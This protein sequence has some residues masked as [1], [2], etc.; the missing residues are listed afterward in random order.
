MMRNEGRDFTPCPRCVWNQTR[1][2][3]FSSIR[4][5]AS[6][7]NYMSKRKRYIL[8]EEQIPRQW[9][10][11]QADM[12][13]KPMPPLHP[14]TR[15]PLRPE[16]L[17]PVFA[18]ELCHQELNQ[19][20]AWI[21]IPDDVREKYKYYR[22]TPLVRA[23]GLE[24]AL[25]TPA[26]IYFKNESVSPI[27]SHKINS[28]L[29]QAYYCKQEGVTNVT[30][31]T[32]AGQWGAALSYAAKVY[33]LEAAVYQVKISYEQKP[34]RRSVMQVFG[35]QVT[36][37]PSM[38]TRAGKDILTVRPNYQGSL[39]TA[40]S[41]AIELARMTPNCKYTLGS[42]LSHVTLHQT[43]IGLEAEKQME[44]AG[45]Y[46]D[47]VIA[48]FGGGSNFGGLAF[49][50]MR[51]NIKDGK[52]TR[53]IAAEPESCPKLTRGKFRYDFGDEAGYTPLLPMFTLGHNF[54]P[55][56][57]HAGGLRYHG[58]GVIVSQLLMDGLMEAVDIPQL[59]SF[60]AGVL[61][62]RTEGI[63][64]A[65]ESCH[66]IAATV[67]EALKC[68]ETGEKKVILFNLSGHGLIDMASYDQYNS[69]N[70]ANYSI[71]DQE[72]ERNLEAL[73]K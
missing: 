45:E 50:F 3:S 1:H 30:T 42:V 54:S 40:I 46:P 62:A 73:D 51:H 16:D 70:L 13:N 22:S 35:A 66:A 23:Y 37:S 68:K 55:A 60:D 36:P 58:A 34:Y 10:N 32:G 12:V 53:F 29:P 39:G 26:H 52:T 14:E 43:V 21:D 18:R 6:K 72:I 69:G 24:E 59:E 31:E 5:Y 2:I 19:T 48:C 38:S 9:Y 63:I 65:P 25:G 47:I 4:Q 20:D 44:M 11:I 67:R 49:P 57:I 28:A 61:F 64:P 27:G 33:G 8:D 71:S 56:N 41:E 15:Q 7:S 17:Y